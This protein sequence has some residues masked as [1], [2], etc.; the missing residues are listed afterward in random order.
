MVVTVIFTCQPRK[1][2][3]VKKT[4]SMSYILPPPAKP[5]YHQ[6]N[7]FRYDS[8]WM[9]EPQELYDQ[10]KNIIENSNDFLERGKAVA[11]FLRADDLA[12]KGQPIEY[13]DCWMFHFGAQVP[14]NTKRAFE[15]AK[16]TNNK[17]LLAHYY[18]NGGPVAVDRNRA[19]KL[20]KEIE[21]DSGERYDYSPVW[22]VAN[23]WDKKQVNELIENI[24]AGKPVDLTSVCINSYAYGFATCI[25]NEWKRI[26]AQADRIDRSVYAAQDIRGKELFLAYRSELEQFILVHDAFASPIE[27]KGGELGDD[28]EI[29]ETH[30][31][32]MLSL[33]SYK[34]DTTSSLKSAEE[35]LNKQYKAYVSS[36]KDKANIYSHD[37][38]YKDDFERC[39]NRIVFLRNAEEAWLNYRDAK[40]AFIAYVHRNAFPAEI[41]EAD[42][43]AQLTMKHTKELSYYVEFEW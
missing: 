43:K 14:V 19:I 24:R 26:S 34:P 1:P 39:T 20:I 5:R 8:S 7:D 35:Q 15:C 38:R 21:D 4:D 6:N 30:K 12:A 36:L 11:L 29:I 28:I 25:Y 42:V 13:E 37:D 27:G 17:L 31:Q 41:V 22:V 40:A 2:V 3:E 10:A 9:N 32:S 16:R 23:E 33:S 18:I